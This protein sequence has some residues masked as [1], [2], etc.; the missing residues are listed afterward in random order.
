MDNLLSN[1]IKYSPFGTT[2]RVRVLS[3]NGMVRVE[4]QDEGPGIS[5]EDMQKLFGKF[6][7]LSAQPTGPVAQNQIS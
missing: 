4:I 3:V 6:A 5:A 1:A 2:V 7:R